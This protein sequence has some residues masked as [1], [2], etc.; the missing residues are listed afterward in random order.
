MRESLRKPAAKVSKEHWRDVPESFISKLIL[1]RYSYG[2][3]KTYKHLF[4]EFIN[5]YPTRPIDEI[6]EAEIIAYLRHLVQERAVSVSYQNQ[7]S[8]PSSSTMNKF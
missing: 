7:A 8:M 3:M 1:R 2:T 6:T 5:Y 4:R